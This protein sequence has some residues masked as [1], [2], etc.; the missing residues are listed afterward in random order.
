MSNQ[1]SK[2]NFARVLFIELSLLALFAVAL[3]LW[4]A[5]LISPS[6]QKEILSVIAVIGLLPVAASAW[7]SLIA[8]KINVD[9]L[10]T[11][12]LFFSFITGEWGSLLFI[13]LMLS[14]ARLLG[15][16]TERRA[17]TSLDSLAKLKPSQA[18]VLRGIDG[19]E[20]SAE[21]P[22][23]EVRIGDLVM[24]GLGEQI[25]VDG[26][27][28]EGAATVDQSSL[29]GESMPVLRV[30]N[31]KV[32][33][34]TTI[35]SG[36]IV[37]RAKKVGAQT[38][39]ERMIALV[40]SSQAA[41][42]RMNTTAERFASWYIGGMLFVSVLI[43]A[44][45]F[46]TKLVLAVVL[47]VCA[48][49]IAIAIP[50]AYVA[51]IGAAARRGIIIKSADFLERAA[52]ITTL[53]VDKTG[54][55]TIGHLAVKEFYSFSAQGERGLLAIASTA[56]KNS[57]HP[58]SKAI[59]AYAEKQG[60]ASKEPD[61]IEEAEGRGIQS[62]QEGKNILIGRVEFLRERGIAIGEETMALLKKIEGEGNN[63]TLIAVN[64][65]TQGLFA[66]SDE[67]R[68]GVAATIASLKKSG[69]HE[70]VML[71]G[72]NKNAAARIATSAG[73]GEY[74]AGL[75]PEQKVSY[76]SVHLGK[77]KT[78]AMV[79]DGVNDAAVITRADIGIAMGTIGTDAAI[80]SA[81]IVLMEDDFGKLA[82]LR[83]IARK[84]IA[85]ARENF[86]IW[87]VVNGIG[88]YFVFTGV[89]DPS[90]AA[91]YNFLTDFIPIANSLRLF[92][93]RGKKI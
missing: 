69:L 93:H 1:K 21:I 87:A 38:T 10:A 5:D 31:D 34:A 46:D 89:F 48:D 47:V 40:E 18:R 22:L 77:G 78:V 59:V 72:D 8:K 74:H 24:V 80:D 61:H 83:A 84:V 67:L 66:L 42:T 15:L 17:R 90:K 19:E 11:I 52:K 14:S 35:A 36:H 71:T 53:V 33:S 43:Y 81:D 26:V 73:I 6:F 76:L 23:D 64:G 9:L 91:A 75:L 3:A 41:K 37:V 82:E 32:F 50:L 13:N 65:E 63:A 92:N 51:S 45:T 49:D 58:V 62:S 25:P 60:V 28:F 57:S 39:F 86:A 54:T 56:C 20:R 55:L 4:I 44:M 2:Q 7:R 12:A 68:D 85:V 79:G 16:Y 27:V 88:L 30:K 70:M 29:T